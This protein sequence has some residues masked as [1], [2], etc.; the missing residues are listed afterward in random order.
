VGKSSRRNSRQR[1][2]SETVLYN[3]G[4]PRYKIGAVAEKKRYQ[5]WAESIRDIGILFLVFAPL[6][7][8]ILGERGKWLDWLIATLVAVVGYLLIEKGVRM[9]SGR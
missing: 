7:T 8:L 4:W 9:E 5:L 3:V 1:G 6:D 2:W